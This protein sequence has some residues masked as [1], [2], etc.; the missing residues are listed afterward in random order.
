MEPEVL[1]DWPRPDIARIRINRPAR[2]NA[3]TPEL[4]LDLEEALASQIAR[5][6][7][8]AVLLSGAGGHFCAGG[9]VAR[10]ASL[11]TADVGDLLRSAHRLIR[12][13]VMSEKPVI[14]AIAGSAAGGGFGLAMACDVV[15]MAEDAQM[16]LPFH[17]LGLVPDYG[18]AYTL[19]RRLGSM[20]AQRLMLLPR[21]LSSAEALEMGLA[22]HVVQQAE[23]EE[24]SLA[25]AQR[26]AQQSALAL[27]GI[28]QMARAQAPSLDA[29][30]EAEIVAQSACFASHEFRAGVSEFLGRSHRQSM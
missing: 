15:V 21:N 24:V 9:D 10:L 4:R 28:K 6:D 3:I 16:V 13:L 8:R 18:L 2:R 22:D 14:A 17:R 1:V 23:L 29:V 27:T 7:V 25:L 20:G 11:P 26:V 19:A 12:L 5:S 30:L